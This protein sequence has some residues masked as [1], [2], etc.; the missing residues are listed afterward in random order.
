MY[1][2][3]KS[4]LHPL[5]LLLARV[6]LSVLLLL[7]AIVF[8]Q[9]TK[10]VKGYGPASYT[11][12]GAEEFMRNWLVAG[13]LKVS[14]EGTAPDEKKQVEFF[15]S[16]EKIQVPAVMKGKAIPA[17][18]VSG[19]QLAWSALSSSN[20]IIDLDAHFKSP[21]FVAAYAMAEIVA[22]DGRKGFLSVGSD[23]GVR[24]WHNGKLIH[25]NWTPRGVEKD[26][27]LVPIALSKGSN[28][29]VVK[30][31]DI[32]GGFG[33]VIRLL[34]SQGLSDRFV[35]A[36]GRGDMDQLT[37]LIDAGV[38]INAK[39]KSAFTAVAKAK[40]H[41]REEVVKYLL[42]KGAENSA[43]P[44]PTAVFD[45]LYSDL[46]QK[47]ASGIALLV[48]RNGEILYKKGFGFADIQGNRPINADT[49]FR[50][51][52][53]TKQFTA[54]AILRLQEDGK[55][56]VNDKLS[57]FFP[58]FPRAGEVTIHHLLTHVSGIHSYTSKSD[59][60]A[61]VV[62]PI[63]EKEL[64]EYFKNDPYDFNPGEKF[65]Y[66]NSGYF[67]LGEIVAKASGMTYG[68]YLQKEFFGPL[69]M[70]ST[71]VHTPKAKLDNEALGYAKEGEK[72]T[73]APN[74][75][76]A[77][78]GAAGALYSNVEDLY[79]WNEALFNGKVLKSESIK[80]AHT[81]VVLNN[82]EAPPGG[83][84]G[85][86]WGLSEY[87]GVDVIAHGGGL[88]GFISQ[89][90]R[91]PEHNL[92]VVML[93]N[94]TP[95]ELDMN[96]HSVAELYLW[97]KMDKQAAKVVNTDVKEDVRKYEGRY[98]FQNG[99]VMT[100]TSEGQNLFAQLSGQQ[101]FP[102][103]PAGNAEYFWKVVDA[104]IKFHTNEN[105]EVDYGDFQQNGAKL[106]V[107]KLKDEAIVS[108]NKELYK[109]YAGKYDYGNNFF[110]TVTAEN[111]RIYA[112]GTNQPK[113]EI[114]PLSETDFTIKE[115]NARLTFVKEPD[116]KVS[117]MILDM[118]GQKK[119]APRIE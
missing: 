26:S 110:V 93:T 111:D 47:K 73:L 53:I 76:M 60:I 41:G 28:Q 31:Q 57:K 88:H 75:D 32:Q 115:V 39:D 89:L 102:I 69:G 99:A 116:G 13:P 2:R 48:S 70:A 65:L 1:P 3:S 118:G 86:G 18:S 14:P 11:V 109:L 36:A 96:P 92:T 33:F 80:A 103:F 30:V 72:Y 61:K 90:A 44:D 95:P 85:Y 20:D 10:P 98:D 58:D 8:A 63:T 108:I 23:D 21:D 79:K 55:L 87:R 59:F 97:D 45:K 94:L 71:G 113:F 91:Y 43:I 54:A 34:N 119:D 84:Y 77:W 25:D 35:A 7:P 66:N 51:G 67:L 74:W 78:A 24:I 46:N 16:D 15:K 50:I 9:K 105:G 29:I 114:F 101:R 5:A 107:V 104:R 62:N 100:I 56:T 38:D 68:E 37:Q 4:L 12:P 42:D 64:I 19:N 52:S 117:K 17:L 81:S 6:T 82:G 83:G 22:E 27:D 106:K 49:K 40:M 112:Q